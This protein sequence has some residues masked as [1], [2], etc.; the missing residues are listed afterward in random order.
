MCIGYIQIL[1][2]FYIKNMNYPGL[3]YPWEVL[4]GIPHGYRGMTVYYFG[5]NL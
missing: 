4:D 3:W 1:T 5:R 2:L